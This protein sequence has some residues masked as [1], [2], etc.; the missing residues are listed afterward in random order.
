MLNLKNIKFVRKIQTIFSIIVFISALIAVNSF[1][2]T[3]SMEKGKNDLFKNYIEPSNQIHNLFSRIKR[4][5]FTLLKF[6]IPAFGDEINKNIQFVTAEKNSIDQIFNSLSKKT[7]N[8][9]LKSNLEEMKKIW[10]TYKN[11]VC[12]AIISAGVIK[13]YEMA[14]VITTSSGEEMAAQIET[15]STLL[16]K[17]F[18]QT[19]K[20]LD[21]KISESA[22]TSKTFLFWGLIGSAV[23]II[24]TFVKVAPSLTK[25]I[26]KI[27]TLMAEHSKGQYNTEIVVDSKDEFGQLLEMLNTIKSAQL[28]KISAAKNIA[29]GRF[30]KV[31]PASEFDE[32]AFA[33]NTMTDTI[34]NLSSEI[35]SLT[36]SAIEGE[37]S[38]RADFAIFDGEYKDILK[39]INKIIDALLLPVTEGL[40]ILENLAHGKLNARMKGEYS[41]E[42]K[43]LKNSLIKWANHYLIQYHRLVN[44]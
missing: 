17:Y 36:K 34:R 32:L 18:V 41:G 38:K 3:S 19:A 33:F 44:Q 27:K 29:S 11:I 8:P 21:V 6:S 35:G 12:D 40:K 39:G 30:E 10:S 37:L 15:K 4:L 5:Q 26:E 9:E 7:F 28:E 14:A 31:T 1:I 43:L 25:P 22:N 24:I 13:D 42:H 23:I 20:T 16:D 2:Q